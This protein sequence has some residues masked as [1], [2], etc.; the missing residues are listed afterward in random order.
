M[1]ACAASIA[2]GWTDACQTAILL[3]TNGW[4]TNVDDFVYAVG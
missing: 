3:V 1:T 2:T 4:D